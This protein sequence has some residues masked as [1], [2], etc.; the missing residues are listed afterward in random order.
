MPSS[1]QVALSM[2]SALRLT[3]S[4]AFYYLAGL[5]FHYPVL[6]MYYLYDY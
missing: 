4:L 6:D 1:G 5:H 3:P 2:G